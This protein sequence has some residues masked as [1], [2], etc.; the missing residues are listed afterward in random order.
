MRISTGSQLGESLGARETK[1]TMSKEQQLSSKKRIPI[2][3]TNNKEQLS[4]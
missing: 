4:P 3:P 2:S 1:R